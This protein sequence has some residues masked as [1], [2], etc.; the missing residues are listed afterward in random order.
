MP[1][2]ISPP[3]SPQAA[4]T[5]TATSSEFP[6]L[7]VNDGPLDP[8]DIFSLHPSYPTEDL[9]ELRARYE[10]DGYLF[11]KGLLPRSDVLRARSAYFTSLQPTG[12][13]DPSTSPVDGIFDSSKDCLQYPGVGAGVIGNGRKGEGA[14]S[15]F[16]ELAVKAHTED[17]YT[18]FCEHSALRDFIA[19]ISGWGESTL[20]VKRSLLRNN[21]PGNQ[22]I[23]VHYDQIFLR[24]G[25]PTSYTAWVPIGDV[26]VQGGGL[27]YLENGKLTEFERSSVRSRIC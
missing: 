13:L 2:L 6:P 26:G 4:A 19:K 12:V 7:F 3:T 5:L 21:V 16:V 14:S 10:R 17:W 11:L 25:E 22:A 8:A 20:G 23:G 15:Q 1:H 18:E 24:H 27:I 9:T